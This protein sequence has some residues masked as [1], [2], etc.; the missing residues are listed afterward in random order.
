MKFNGSLESIQK[1]DWLMFCCF[2]SFSA[3]SGKSN[4]SFPHCKVDL[5]D[6]WTENW[7]S[8]PLCNNKFK[9]LG[10]SIWFSLF[11]K[12]QVL[13]CLG[14]KLSHFNTDSS[15]KGQLISKWFFGVIDFL[16]KTNER[17]QV[18]LRYHSSKVKFVLSFFWRKLMT[19]KTNFEIN[20]P[21]ANYFQSFRYICLRKW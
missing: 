18:D 13:H 9:W 14:N 15:D 19:P 12:V 2:D 17:K 16:Q 3:C 21:L 7:S 5:L 4:Y 11:M 20:W 10:D 6:F 1:F 8:P